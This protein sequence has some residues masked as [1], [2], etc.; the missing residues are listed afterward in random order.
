MAVHFSFQ[1]PAPPR[2]LELARQLRWKLVNLAGFAGRLPP[3]TVFGGAMGVWLPTDAVVMA[4]R[5]R[6]VPVVRIGQ[7]PHPQDNR[8]PA[9]MPDRA[10]AGRLAAEHFA[11]LGFDH[12][13]Y[14]G[15]RPWA[16]NEALF[17]AFAA[18]SDELGCETLLLQEDVEQLRPRAGSPAELLELRRRAFAD[19][20]IEQ[21]R[22]LGLLT[23]ADPA[24]A[25]YCHWV[26]DA[27]LRVPE[28]VA[29]LGI[30]NEAFACECADVP[31]SSIAFDEADLAEA[32]VGMLDKLMSGQRLERTTVTTRPIGVV[33]RQSTDVLA[34]SDPRVVAALRFMW[35]HIAEDLSVD[36]IARHVGVA[37]RTLERAFEHELGRGVYQE[38][39]RRRLDLARDH[40]VQTDRAMG[41]IAEML[42]FNSITAFGRAFRAEYGL[43][44]AQYR[45]RH[46]HSS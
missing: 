46:R 37:R 17:D 4:L 18:R 24:A 25:L 3:R 32:A 5:E 9:V 10:A 41:R 36:H 27:G 6:G 1:S 34:A 23:F 20:L 39:L 19:W 42:G 31:L 40:V 33:T 38:Y 21:P 30:G 7:R 45:R 15:R 11:S 12:V 26:I 8:V 2:L 13:A 29:V 16:G 28:D 35:D 22:P 44:P 14:I 43:S